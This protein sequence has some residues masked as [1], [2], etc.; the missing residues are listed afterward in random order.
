ML[1]REDL[2]YTIDT[3]NNAGVR[4]WVVK[5][6]PE[7]VTDPVRQLAWASITGGETDQLGVSL[8]EHQKKYI[9]CDNDLLDGLRPPRATVLDPTAVFFNTKGYCQLESG[10]K[11]IFYDRD[12]LTDFGTQS[13]VPVLAPMFESISRRRDGN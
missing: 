9:A 2:Y 5:Q 3:L 11:L 6:I 8:I 12:H 13:L 7:Q 10:G 1:L 4:V